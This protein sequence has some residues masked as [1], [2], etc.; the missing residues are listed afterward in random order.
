MP[1]ERTGAASDASETLL[2]EC[3]EAGAPA[4][5]LEQIC[6]AH[7]EHAVVLR[8][9]FARAQ[10]LGLVA[11]PTA[12]GARQIGDYRLIRELGR[13]GMGV[14]WL[15]EQ[16]SLGR[17]VALKLLRPGF[18]TEAL[19][20]RLRREAAVL[21]QLRHV[22]IAHIYE[23]GSA[24]LDDGYGQPFFAMEY[25]AGLALDVYAQERMLDM[26]ARLTL[27]A[28]VADAVAHA[29]SQGVIH[30]DLKPDNILIE[31]TG[32]PKILDFGIARLTDSDIAT[33][34]MQTAAG[35]V[36][37]TIPYMSPEQVVGDSSAIDARTDVYA[38]GV[39]LYE[40]LS[41]NVPIDVRGK[42]I[43]EA[44]R[45]IQEQDPTRLSTIATVYR[46][47]V[48]TIVDKALAK[49]K[50]RRYLSA[51]AFAEDIRRFL[52]HEPIDAR[53]AS[54]FY[55]LRKF[56]KRHRGLVGGLITAFVILVLGV[57]VATDYAVRADRSADLAQEKVR[58]FDQLSGVVL[59]ERAIFRQQE[60]HPPWPDR[61]AAM[62]EWLMNDAGRLLAMQPAIEATLRSLDAPPAIGSDSTT[63]RR[64]SLT[65]SE[66]RNFLRDTLRQLLPKL[67]AL[68]S[69]VKPAVEQRLGWARSIGALTLSH[70]HARFTW[71]DAR[72]AIERADDVVASRLYR[73]RKV[74]LRDEDVIGLVPIGPNP[75]TK[76]WE[77][78]DLRSAWDGKR[79]P[80]S[81]R[82]PEHAPDGSIEVNDD[83][84]IV[85]VLLP[86]GTFTMGAQKDDPDQPNFDELTDFDEQPHEVDLTPFFLSRYE[87][88]QG[89]WLRLWNGDETERE[90]SLSKAG[91][92]EGDTLIT[93][94][95]PVENVDRA[96]CDLLL[97][98]HGMLLP[99]EAQWEYGCRAGS[100][101][102]WSCDG[103]ELKRFA[104]LADAT[105][106][107]AGRMWSCEPWTDGCI[108]PTRVGSF[109][110]N[111]FGLHDVHGNILEWCR[112]DYGAYSGPVRPGDGLRLEGIGSGHGIIR[113]GGANTPAISA[114]SAARFS[115]APT[116]RRDLGLRPARP[117]HRDA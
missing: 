14:V 62:E 92:R 42:S 50:E 32:Q 80:D 54:T 107:A 89:Q 45:L 20:K 35:E 3:L 99:T 116:V 38:L 103:A 56:A 64:I 70:S 15:A 12:E 53:P 18:G 84:G 27:L 49:E 104:N 13:G 67:A 98:Q 26:A 76:L 91:N 73:G 41:G 111:A 57:V 85:F 81:I 5:R 25:V 86:G 113:G 105:A 83:L 94:A 6:A 52:R 102:S 40:L 39:I 44:A 51:A 63:F 114:R 43:A 7:P 58:E 74:E 66:S 19:A 47:D 22:G 60:L 37:G 90:P 61:V 17:Q 117:L 2:A 115:L 65:E 101:G 48:E 71:D 16:R 23:A 1:E 106:R 21:G 34:T 75:V 46:G 87:M 108:D 78:Y 36:L 109:A 82:I 68:G 10:G 93:L 30:R 88:T 97:R 112:D 96:M 69:T 31:R 28:L 11:G 79:A 59:Y 110:P 55:H 77:F 9:R 24:V 29:H 95:N 4:E 100:T 8:R 72:N 33:V